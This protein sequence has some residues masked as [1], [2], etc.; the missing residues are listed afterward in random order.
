MTKD[1]RHGRGAGSGGGGATAEGRDS[2]STMFPR[3]HAGG[4]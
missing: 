1:V 2:G 3:G 4:M